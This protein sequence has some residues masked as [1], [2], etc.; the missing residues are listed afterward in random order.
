MSV[1][2]CVCGSGEKHYLSVFHQTY[3]VRCKH[4]NSTSKDAREGFLKIGPLFGQ[5]FAKIGFIV[6]NKQLYELQNI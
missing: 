5:K 2:M 4:I 6:I 3:P 1:C